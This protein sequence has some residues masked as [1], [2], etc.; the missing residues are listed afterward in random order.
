MARSKGGFGMKHLM[1]VALTT[2]VVMAVVNRVPALS[3]VVKGG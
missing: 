3:T 2:L 1:I